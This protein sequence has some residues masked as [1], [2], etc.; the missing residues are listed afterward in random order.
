ME[1]GSTLVYI[2]NFMVISCGEWKKSAFWFCSTLVSEIVK[3]N[4][5]KADCEQVQIKL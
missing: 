4:L 2:G 5:S 3:N 1:R